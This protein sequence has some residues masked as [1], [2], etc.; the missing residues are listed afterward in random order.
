MELSTLSLS[1]VPGIEYNDQSRD[2]IE[3]LKHVAVAVRT[4]FFLLIYLYYTAI[5]TYALYIAP[6]CR[7][8]LSL[9]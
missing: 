5:F 9:S 4:V 8:H 3:E 7:P 6:Y 2:L 1:N